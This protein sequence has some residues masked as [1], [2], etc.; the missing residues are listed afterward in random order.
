MPIHRHVDKPK[1]L[2]KLY[3]I[4]VNG[5]QLKPA[6]TM[7]TTTTGI[8]GL[9]IVMTESTVSL[10]SF[11]TAAAIAAFYRYMWA[12]LSTHL[13]NL[14]SFSLV[15]HHTKFQWLKIKLYKTSFKLLKHYNHKQVQTFEVCIKKKILFIKC[16]CLNWV[17]KEVQDCVG[18]LIANAHTPFATRPDSRDTSPL[19]HQFQGS[20]G[21][22]PG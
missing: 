21:N 19:I 3:G 10:F 12:E 4:S 6:I 20:T 18:A 5:S 7:T 17:G 11:Y 16:L 2:C 8:Y 1:I 14:Y 13:N 9:S 22:I 15:I